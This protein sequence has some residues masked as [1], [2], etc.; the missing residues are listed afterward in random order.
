[1][2]AVYQTARFEP[3]EVR[4]IL[5]QLRGA[6]EDL[7]GAALFAVDV[8]VDARHLPPVLRGGNVALENSADHRSR[9]AKADV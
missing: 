2:H 1:L 9:H 4:E 7:S 6:L 8:D 5:E 3:A